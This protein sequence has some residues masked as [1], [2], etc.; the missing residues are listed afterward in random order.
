MVFGKKAYGAKNYIIVL[1]VGIAIGLVVSCLVTKY[2]GGM[3]DFVTS[4]V[5]MP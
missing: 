3:C 5:P 2:M 4:Q 1:I